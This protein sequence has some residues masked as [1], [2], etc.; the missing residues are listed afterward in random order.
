MLDADDLF[1]TG[2]NVSCLL[3]KCLLNCGQ[4]F[5]TC[6]GSRF[7]L[8]SDALKDGAHEVICLPKMTRGKAAEMM[9]CGLKAGCASG[10]G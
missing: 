8:S 10:N 5:D 9:L 7:A 1:T 6:G 2:R 4:Y 3:K